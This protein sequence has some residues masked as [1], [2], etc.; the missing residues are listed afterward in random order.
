MY[1]AD[2]VVVIFCIFAA[3]ML[4]YRDIML[5]RT[6]ENMQECIRIGI[7]MHVVVFYYLRVYAFFSSVTATAKHCWLLN[8]R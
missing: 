1:L 4:R 5:F 6:L 7:L 8:I 3:G 2:M